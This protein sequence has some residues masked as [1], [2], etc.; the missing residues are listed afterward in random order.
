MSVDAKIIF[1][2]GAPNKKQ[3]APHQFYLVRRFFYFQES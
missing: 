2:E 3:K 1:A